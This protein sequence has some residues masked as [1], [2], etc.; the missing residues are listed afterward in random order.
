MQLSFLAVTNPDPLGLRGF[1]SYL[2]AM[3]PQ[4]AF[5]AFVGLGAVLL[6][7]GVWTSR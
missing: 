6:V 7:Y 4:L 5:A 3:F 2:S 1:T